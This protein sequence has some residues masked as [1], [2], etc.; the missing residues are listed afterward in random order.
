MVVVGGDGWVCVCVCVLC[1]GGGGGDSKGGGD[2][3]TARVGG[4]GGHQHCLRKQLT[5]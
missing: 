3:Q 5:R 1:G 2:W 4:Q